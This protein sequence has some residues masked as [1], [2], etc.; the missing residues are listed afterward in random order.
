MSEKI[1]IT[2]AGNTAAPAFALLK[3]LGYDVSHVHD[4]QGRCTEW[5]Q[6]ERDT[7][8]LR[9]EDPLALLGLAKLVECKGAEWRSSQQEI[10]EYLDFA[11]ES[12]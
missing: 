3:Q 6:A 4:P 11:S 2:I 9:A 5:L 12:V 8:V 7:C 1:A 10:D